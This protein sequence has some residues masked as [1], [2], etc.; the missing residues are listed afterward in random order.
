M[1]KASDNLTEDLE[2]E[3]QP[4]PHCSP[5]LQTPRPVHLCLTQLP[6]Y[7][8]RFNL[9][10]RAGGYGEIALVVRTESTCLGLNWLRS[11]WPLLGS[12]C[13]FVFDSI[14]LFFWWMW[15]RWCLNEMQEDRK[16][17]VVTRTG[18]RGWCGGSSEG[19]W[20]QRD[21]FGIIPSSFFFFF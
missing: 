7:R 8:T 15:K 14:C 11:L 1:T 6:H 2:E 20:R 9:T 19:K 4:A 13:L 18:D 12:V 21:G 10:T 3:G 16:G 5:H 17:C